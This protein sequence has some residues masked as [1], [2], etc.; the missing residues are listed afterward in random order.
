MVFK[1]RNLIA[2]LSNFICI[3]P[4]GPSIGLRSSQGFGKIVFQYQKDRLSIHHFYCYFDDGIVLGKTKAELW[5][6]REAVHVQIS[7]IGLK[8]RLNERVFLT[9]EASIYWD[10]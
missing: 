8:M 3:M 10:R 6:I 1:D 9:G 5:K 4:T 7:L 2:M